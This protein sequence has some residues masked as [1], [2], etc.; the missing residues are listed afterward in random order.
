MNEEKNLFSDRD[1]APRSKGIPTSIFVTVIC[2]VAAFAVLFTFTVTSAINRKRYGDLLENGKLP[3]GITLTDTDFSQLEL[4]ASIFEKYGYYAGEASEEELVTAVLK[5]YAEATGDNYAEYYTE[6]EY[7]EIVAA[8]AGDLVGI[9][10]SVIQTSIKIDSVEHPVYQV[11]AV[12][13]KAPAANTE[14][15]VGDYIYSLETEN[16]TKTIAE[17]GYTKFLSSFKGAVGTTVKFSFFRQTENGYESKSLSI[18]RD[19]FESTSVKSTKSEKDPKVGIVQI[20]NFDLTTPVQLKKAV[21]G[22]L[23]E[24]VERFVF[25]VRNNPGGDLQSIKAVLSYFLQENDLILS[26]ID[27]NG[28]VAQSYY[29]TPAFHTGEY[30]SCNVAKN[31]IGMYAN[32]DMVVL[33]NENTASAAEVFT[34]TMRDYGLAKIVGETTFGKGIMQSF[35]PLAAFG[36]QYSGYLKLTSYAYVTK[37]GVTYHDIGITPSVTV[38]LSDEAKKYNFYVLPQS[39]DNQLQTAIAQFE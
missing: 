22:L 33:C 9:G 12:Y 21:N 15:S 3:N 26:S 7:A 6:A 24:G 18:V 20:N 1:P 5:A 36:G 34:A 16:G 4:L 39:L 10:V 14:L 13:E 23:A 37:C 25:D 35:L 32:L 38:A 27:R 2:L 17:L 29:A 19:R 11:I 31:E 8:N 28:S 30:A